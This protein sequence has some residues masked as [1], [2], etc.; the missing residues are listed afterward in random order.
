MTSV[1]SIYSTSVGKKLTMAL[2]GTMFVLF[3]IVHMLGNM[4]IYL[5]PDKFNAYAQ[6]L[7][8]FGAPFLGHGQFLW[9]VRAV[10][11]LAVLLHVLSAWQL[12][13]MSWA[14][15]G[16][17][18]KRRAALELS[19]ASRMMRWG[20][21]VIGLFI[22]FHLMHLTVGS[23]HHDF[24]DGDAYHN[25]VA[26]FQVPVV[27][28]FY[29]L[30]MVALGLHLYHGTWSAF[31]TLGWDSPRIDRIRRPLAGAIA[32]V[33]MIGNLSFPVTVLTGCIE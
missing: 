27:S 31:Q 7:R 32:F 18:Y 1:Q 17:R 3:V 6:G 20:G 21:V 23:M 8:E 13:R 12:T 11:V 22:L 29:M 15:T 10:L 19:Y 14:A 24:I 25:F 30:A 9:I 16:G 28:G 26:G 4:K 2:T 5:G 33:V